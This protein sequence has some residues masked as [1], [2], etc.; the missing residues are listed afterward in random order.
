MKFKPSP[1]FDDRKLGT[2][3]YLIVHYTGM[4]TGQQA[5]DR[6]CDPVASV[7]A[8]YV[9]EENGDIYA[10][11]DEEKRAWHAGVSKWEDDEDINDLSIGIEIVNP[12]HPYPGYDSVYRPFPDAQM[13]AVLDLAK[14]V[15]DRHSIAP[16]YVLGHSDVAWQRKIDPGELFDWE[17]LARNHVGLWPDN[18]DLKNSI[19]FSE[20]TFIHNLSMFGYDVTSDRVNE[21]TSAFQRHFRQ[22]RVDGIIDQETFLILDWLVTRKAN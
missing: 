1:N 16:C 2:I 6:L 11:V 15:V 8:H 10:L 7:S 5:I 4:A 17:F 18:I 3:K 19:E 13:D 21:A 14:G 9:V 20:D 12:G 22:S